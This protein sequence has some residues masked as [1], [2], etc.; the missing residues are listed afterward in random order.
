M[1]LGKIQ[2]RGVD[3]ADNRTIYGSILCEAD[4]VVDGQEG[5]RITIAVAEHD[6]TLTSGLIL[7]GGNANG[8]VDVIIGAGATSVTAIS[9]T[10]DLGERNITN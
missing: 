10:L 2:F 8:E 9:G 6:G 1:D 3:S 4:P 5:G 7:E